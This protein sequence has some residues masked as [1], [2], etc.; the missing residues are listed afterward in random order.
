M[1]AMRARQAVGARQRML[2]AACNFYIAQGL[3]RATTRRS[4]G[5]DV[6]GN[7]R[8]ERNSLRPQLLRTK[9]A[10]RRPAEKRAQR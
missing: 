6:Q 5:V 2:E 9:N 1:Y 4:F 10:A 8:L 7:L 3:K